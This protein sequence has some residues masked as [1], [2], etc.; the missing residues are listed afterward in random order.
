MKSIIKKYI[1]LAFLIVFSSAAL[2]ACSD[3]KPQEEIPE[4]EEAF[5]NI[6]DSAVTLDYFDEYILDCETKN[7]EKVTWKSSDPSIVSVDENGRLTSF[8]AEGSCEIKA[9][10]GNLSDSCSITVLKKSATPALLVENE[11]VISVDSEY[12]VTANAYY[13]GVSL[14]D[15]ITFNCEP[16]QENADEIVD[17]KVEGNS[18]K[19][20]GKTKGN[21]SF[22]LSTTIF[23]VLYAENINVEVKEVGIYYVVSGEGVYDGNLQIRTDNEVYVSDVEIYENG[24]RVANENLNWEIADENVASIGAD[25]M[26]LMG[27]EGV[28]KLSTTY[29]DT[30]ISVSVTVAKD[31]S[32]ITLEQENPIILDLN[33]NI[34]LNAA[35]KTRTLTVNQNQVCAIKLTDSQEQGRVV[36]AYVGNESLDV[37]YCDYESGAVRINAEAF[38]TKTFGEQT[39][40][41]AVETSRNV[42]EYT[43]KALIATKV[44]KAA[45]DFKTA[46]VAQWGGDRILGYYI[47]GEDLDFGWNE[48]SVWATDWN[49]SNGFRGTLDGMDHSLKNV[50]S[51]FYGLTAQVGEGAVFKNIKF[52]NYKYSGGETTLFARG[53]VGATFE[54]IEITLTADSEC[55]VSSK[56]NSCGVLVSHDMRRCVYKNI[57]IKADG[58]DLQRIFG[59]T[60]QEKDSSVYENVIIYAN[61]VDFYENEKADVPDGVTTITD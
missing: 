16:N 52:P 46:I 22:T 20:T 41:I 2:A 14:A 50:K 18:L 32:Y 58:K 15:Y 39:L 37:F 45:V 26:L 28:T 23:N 24:Q 34:T 4:P 40:K 56:N 7:A 42:Y 3:K 17:L 53:A 51:V 27:N 8:Y 59:G 43:V 47:L 61:S 48:I 19:F 1:P 33:T 54:N 35:E 13:R 49:W 31:H 10:S 29:K 5:V 6:I 57:T 38:G 12:T 60:N 21:V 36:R 11:V 9:I 30:E 44:L 55:A 25:G